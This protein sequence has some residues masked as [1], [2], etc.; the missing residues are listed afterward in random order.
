M[1]STAAK[2]E[3]LQVELQI[4]RD[5]RQREAEEFDKLEREGNLGADEIAEIAA[6]GAQSEEPTSLTVNEVEVKK[7]D[8]VSTVDDAGV[9]NKAEKGFLVSDPVKKI[10][11]GEKGEVIRVFESF[12]GEK[13][14]GIALR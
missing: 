8:Y 11:L 12:Q 14:I 7:G 1:S 6:R 4:L 10:Y 5:Q 13:C 2:R 9:L 3:A